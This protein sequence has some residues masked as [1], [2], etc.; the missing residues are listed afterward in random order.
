MVRVAGRLAARRGQGQGRL[1]RSGRPQRPHPAVGGHRPA[2]RGRHG[3][4]HRPR[5]RRHHRGGRAGM[6]TRRG[7]LSIAVDQATLLAKSLRPPP[8]KHA[9]LKDPETRFRQRYLEL[10]SDPEVRDRL[11]H[12]LAGH[13]RSAPLPRRPRLRGGRDA[14]AA[15]DLRRG[16]R[17]AV[18]HAPQRARP[19]PLPAHRHR[20]VPQALHRR[21]PREGLRAGQGLPQRGRQ[22]QA[23][24]RVHDGRDLRGLRGLPRRDGHARADGLHGASRSTGATTVTWK[25]EEIDFAPPWRRLD[26]REGLLEASGHR[27]P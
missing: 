25:G 11:H 3:R 19:R 2:G 17:P 21:R 16:R 23:Q 20:A 9:G 8:D 14:D 24:P 5:P 15:A 4:A 27:H 18:H 13:R 6:R 12:P 1:P 26:F 10:M 7:E 22:P